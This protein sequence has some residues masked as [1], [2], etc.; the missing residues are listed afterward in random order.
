MQAPTIGR[1][2]DKARAGVYPAANPLTGVREPRK[3]MNM[4]LAIKMAEFPVATGPCILWDVWGV[5]LSTGFPCADLKDQH[6]S[7]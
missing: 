4:T 2:L 5:F 6:N 1:G 3:E 7:L